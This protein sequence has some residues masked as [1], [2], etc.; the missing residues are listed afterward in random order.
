MSKRLV[1]TGEYVQQGQLIGYV[2]STGR[3][4]GPHLHYEVR[5]SNRKMNPY[6][7][8]IAKSFRKG[9]SLQ[10]HRPD[11]VSNYKKVIKMFDQL[12]EMPTEEV[13]YLHLQK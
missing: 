13:S 9:Y 6:S 1:R 7:R 3:S 8:S 5:K 4:T 12:Q 10:D 11:V 2:G